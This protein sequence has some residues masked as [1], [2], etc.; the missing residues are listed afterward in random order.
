MAKDSS[1]APTQRGKKRYAWNSETI[2]SLREHLGMTQREM[3]D[4]LEVR[5]QTIS[6]WETGFH[7]PHRS[8]QKTLTLVAERVGFNYEAA[9]TPKHSEPAADSDRQIED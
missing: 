2:R 8:T 4:E 6:E 9:F 3:A 7:T 5:Q 1:P